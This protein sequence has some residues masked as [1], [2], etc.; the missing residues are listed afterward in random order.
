[1][2]SAELDVKRTGKRGGYTSSSLILKKT[3]DGKN[4]NVLRPPPLP[5]PLRDA[6]KNRNQYNQVIRDR[7]RELIAEVKDRRPGT[8]TREATRIV[9]Y[10]IDG[11]YK[12]TIP[13]SFTFSPQGQIQLGEAQKAYRSRVPYDEESAKLRK[14]LDKS[15][16]DTSERK[17]YDLIRDAEKQNKSAIALN[18]QF[19]PLD[20]IRAI[21]RDGKLYPLGQAY[22]TEIGKDGKVKEVSIVKTIGFQI[23]GTAIKSTAST[24]TVSA[25]L[26]IRH[27]KEVVKAHIAGRRPTNRLYFYKSGPDIIVGSPAEG[28]YA[29]VRTRMDVLFDNAQKET[30]ERVIYLNNVAFNESNFYLGAD[31]RWRIDPNV[32]SELNAPEIE[33]TYTVRYSYKYMPRFRVLERSLVTA[34]VE[35]A[36]TKLF[37]EI[38]TIAQVLGKEADITIGITEMAVVNVLRQLRRLGESGNN[39][40]S[41]VA[42]QFQVKAVNGKILVYISAGKI[43]NNSDLSQYSDN[44]TFLIMSFVGKEGKVVKWNVTMKSAQTELTDV[45]SQQRVDTP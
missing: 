27:K 45:L 13:P 10:Q 44:D 43:V 25:S 39:T 42:T 1:V 22:K 15:V 36:P 21:G 33:G 14:S 37:S 26:V 8:T 23:N 7:R 19:I 40:I 6:N 17:L 34:G 12:K 35:K 18:D 2:A 16:Y 20:Q 28:G 29:E 4:W 24:I 41:F 9:N 31:G 38:H 32:L 3:Q 30:G 11:S 5:K